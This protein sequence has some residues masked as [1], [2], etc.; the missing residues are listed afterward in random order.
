MQLGFEGTAKEQRTFYKVARAG[1]AELDRAAAH[2]PITG[3]KKRPASTATEAGES[4]SDDNAAD[5]PVNSENDGGDAA[6]K[7]PAA[8]RLAV[9]ATIGGK[10]ELGGES[11]GEEG[12]KNDSEG[13][14]SEGRA[15]DEATLGKSDDAPATREADVD[16]A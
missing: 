6:R 15:A 12:Q 11:A 4:E 5:E 10:E 14:A 16:D 1:Y 7:R 2:W 13:I 9:D 3:A 8:A